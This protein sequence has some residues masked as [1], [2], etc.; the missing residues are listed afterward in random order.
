MRPLLSWSMVWSFI[1]YSL[2]G[3]SGLGIADW[4]QLIRQLPSVGSEACTLLRPAATYQ[5][6]LPWWLRECVVHLRWER[7]YMIISQRTLFKL[8]RDETRQDVFS[9]AE[10][11]SSAILSLGSWMWRS[12]VGSVS[13]YSTVN[14]R[15]RW[16]LQSEY[17]P[18]STLLWA[19]RTPQTPGICRVGP[20]S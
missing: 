11:A 3:I 17:L 20:T 12:G 18:F 5:E 19:Q 9:G 14:G 7:T 8:R 4:F 10:G 2:D 6:E 15:S 1:I 13:W 16:Q